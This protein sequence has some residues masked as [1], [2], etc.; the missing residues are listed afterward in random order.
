MAL[1]VLGIGF[2]LSSIN[3]PGVSLI[4]VDDYCSQFRWVQNTVSIQPKTIP[5][6]LC[7]MSPGACA[8]IAIV[9]LGS[10]STINAFTF[11]VFY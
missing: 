10:K 6:Q 2:Q 3:T 11:I 4:E 5:S 1:V 8:F 7:Y 9:E